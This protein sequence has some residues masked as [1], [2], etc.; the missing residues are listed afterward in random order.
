[1]GYSEMQCKEKLLPLLEAVFESRGQD[2]VFSVARG[3]ALLTGAHGVCLFFPDATNRYLQ[4]EAVFPQFP[5]VGGE[6]SAVPLSDINEPVS[7][8][9]HMGE[10][11]VVTHP[12]GREGKIYRLI[13]QL[14]ESCNRQTASIA[15]LPLMTATKKTHGVALLCFSAVAPAWQSDALTIFMLHCTTALGFSALQDKHTAL[16]KAMSADMKR[17]EQE[18]DFLQHQKQENVFFGLIG[19]SPAMQQVYSLIAKV[20][21]S[22]ASVLIS[23]ETGTGKELVARA[24]HENSRR[25]AGPLICFNCAAIPET[26]VESELFGFSKGAFTGADKNKKGLF[27]Q[28]CGGTVFLDEIGDMPLETQVKILRV[29]QEKC[30]RRLGEATDRKTDVRILAATHRDIHKDMAEKKFREDLYYRLAVFPIELPRLQDRPGDITL[31]ALHFLHIHAKT[32]AKNIASF[33]P[34]ALHLLEQGEYRGNVRELSAIVE[35]AVLMAPVAVA[36]LGAAYFPG[37]QKTAKVSLKEQLKIYEQSIIRTA[38]ESCN[39]SKPEA[40]A[41]LGIPKRTL[42]YKVSKLCIVKK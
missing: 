21:P 26:L 29:L 22:D 3:F 40:A 15:S 10:G 1:M 32:H 36:E 17:L 7:Y 39:W 35:R 16:V 20:A 25:K 41:W 24:I 9:A 6:A 34:Q 23:G 14:D 30:I 28:A 27:E 42:Q 18:R 11:I 31:L 2:Q 12:Y 8:A 37:T 13:G 4:P 33:S 5:C 38:L 19:K